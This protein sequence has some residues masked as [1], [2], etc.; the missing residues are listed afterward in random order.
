ML[1]QELC[2]SK[3]SQKSLKG[4]FEFPGFSA[5]F[6]IDTFMA[7]NPYTKYSFHN[8]FS[9]FSVQHCKAVI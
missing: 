2:I 8:S 3:S 4:F 9:S 6:A 7:L 1:M 5:A